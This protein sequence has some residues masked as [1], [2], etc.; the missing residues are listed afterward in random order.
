MSLLFKPAGDELAT[1]YGE[2]FDLA[3]LSTISVGGRYEVLC[4]DGM[5]YIVEIKQFDPVSFIGHVHFR[6]WKTRFDFKGCIRD[7]YMTTEGRYSKDAGITANNTYETE[8]NSQSARRSSL[9][10]RK[11]SLGEK[12]SYAANT[13]YDDD[14]FAKPRP[15]WAKRRRQTYESEM[16]PASYEERVLV[17]DSSSGEEDVV[18]RIQSKCCFGANSE[19]LILT[20]HYVLHF[21]SKSSSAAFTRQTP[22]PKLSRRSR[23]R[24]R[25]QYTKSCASSKIWCSVDIVRPQLH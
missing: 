9:G 6:H 23:R 25:Y 10:N 22:T 18:S 7:V 19:S 21:D 17:G 15:K 12:S 1:Q 3:A 2:Y 16:M 4:S 14:F 20:K 8:N 5:N 11:L 24:C 13:K